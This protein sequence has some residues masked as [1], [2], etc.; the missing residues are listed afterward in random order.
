MQP[1]IVIWNFSH[2]CLCLQELYA[3]PSDWGRQPL[4]PAGQYCATTTA[5]EHAAEPCT[6]PN[7]Y[8]RDL[9]ATCDPAQP[10]QCALCRALLHS[11]RGGGGWQLEAAQLEWPRARV[12]DIHRAVGGGRGNA[13]TLVCELQSMAQCS[14]HGTRLNA[15][16]WLTCACGQTQ[17]LCVCVCACDC[18]IGT[19][20]NHKL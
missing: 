15:R 7:L 11:L 12:K 20:M 1:Q 10:S 13:C 2:P 4:L 5:T 18:E 3:Q 9:L 16:N 8:R 14:A 17:L 6:P 19:C